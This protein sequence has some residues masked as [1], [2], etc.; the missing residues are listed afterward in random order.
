M[1]VGR[2]RQTFQNRAIYIHMCIYIYTHT[3]VCVY[4]YIYIIAVIR[5][6]VTSFLN[7]GAL[8]EFL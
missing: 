8:Q 7:Y 2:R 5:D 3:Y 6:N 1:K 4:I